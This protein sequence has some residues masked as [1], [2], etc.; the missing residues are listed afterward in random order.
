MG[1]DALINLLPKPLL[2]VLILVLSGFL[3]QYGVRLAS[4]EVALAHTQAEYAQA[5]AEAAK[6]TAADQLK[7]RTTETVLQTAL[8]NQQKDTDAK[9]NDLVLQRDALR[10]RVQSAG[11]AHIVYVSSPAPTAGIKTPADGNN[12]A[13]LPD[14]TQR[15]IDEAYRADEIRVNLLQC[16]ADYDRAQAALAPN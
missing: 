10:V 1:F 5:V 2:I 13:K 16:Y 15:L 12:D 4:T 3:A 7:A 8:T 11:A 14:P 9:V 6:Q